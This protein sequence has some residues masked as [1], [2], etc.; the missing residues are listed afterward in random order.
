MKKSVSYHK[1]ALRCYR[2]SF[3]SSLLLCL[4]QALMWLVFFYGAKLAVTH[5]GLHALAVLVPSLILLITYRFFVAHRL[6][7]SL[8]PSAP[9]M[10]PFFRLL[11]AAFWR[12]MTGALWLLPFAGGT[13]RFYQYIFVLPATTFTFD[14]TQIGAFIAKGATNATQVLIGTGVFFAY[15]AL[16]FVAFLYGWR[17]GNCFDVAQTVNLSF[18]KS[19][20]RARIIRRRTRTARFINSILHLLMLLPAIIVPLI[21]PMMQL[22]PLLSGKAMNDVQLL[23]AYLSAGI[24]SD[25]TLYLS[26]ALFLVLYLPLLPFRKLHNIAAMVIRHE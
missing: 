15:L 6:T 18:R 21:P 19:L 3:F 20:R 9:K 10:K 12:I 11:P 2:Q 16:S 13:Y 7:L 5:L 26:A 17:R 8:A 22:Y 25:N 23:Y 24:V 14:F 1:A 4:S